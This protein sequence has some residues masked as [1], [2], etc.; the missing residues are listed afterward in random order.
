M[1]IQVKIKMLRDR[2]EAGLYKQ[3]CEFA[4][5]KNEYD[6]MR[7][8]K[9]MLE[10]H[11]AN[12]EVRNVSVASIDWEDPYIQFTIIKEVID[13][14]IEQKNIQPCGREFPGF[15]IK[16][17]TSVHFAANLATIGETQTY[18]R[19]KDADSLTLKGMRE[20]GDVIC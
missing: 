9:R 10:L 18:N 11:P 16:V 12:Q 19:M 8:W 7:F 5:G 3:A 15:M 6:R 20:R 13:F 14:Q 2:M 1:D 17:G 4:K